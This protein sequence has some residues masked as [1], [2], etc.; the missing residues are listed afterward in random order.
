[1]SAAELTADYIVVGAGTAGSVLARRL[2]DAGARVLLL[3][4]GGPA[5]NPAIDDPLRMHE[6]WHS[7][8]DWDYFT[9]PQP[10]A[11]GRRLHLPRGRVIGGS[12]ALNAT[13]HVRGNPADYD[14]WAALGNTG[15]AWR[16]VRPVFERI[17]SGP[18]RFHTGFE[19]DPVQSAILAA[20][21]ETGIPFNPD[22]NSGR[23]EGVSTLALTLADGRRCTTASTYLT[24]VLDRP[25]LTVLSGAEAH[26]L[27]FSGGRVSGVRFARA[28]ELLEASAEAEVVLAAGALGSP[29]LL[30]RSGIGPAD[31]L[32]AADV[33]VLL[34]LPG[35][36]RNLQDHWLVPVIFS[37]ER[38]IRHRPGLPHAQTHLFWHSGEGLPAP[39]LQPLHFSVPLYEPW[40]SGPPNGFSLM[41]GLVRPAGTGTVAIT[42]PD[43]AHELHIDPG[44]LA[45]ES[46]LTRLVAAVRLCQE[47]GH[48]P[49]L[50]EWGADERY[51]GR[52]DLTDYVR[53][54]V[55]TYHHQAGTCRMGV[56]EDAVVGPDLL[57]RGIDGLR[58]ADASIMPAV[59]TGNTNTPAILIAEQAAALLGCPGSEASRIQEVR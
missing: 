25:N 34:D 17:E 31:T 8:E 23:Q 22:Y 46:D 51:P 10:S 26:R 53:R 59:T 30:Q 54:A 40:M 15:W 58:V 4:A 44:V 36:G 48:A 33:P 19:P 35:V 11:A 12:H 38:E 18:L 52:A 24:P 39:D 27:L 28:G 7:T 21:Q 42:G 29:A 43:P 6:L 20:A 2:V 47:I 3:E 1:M 50:W 32:R 56:H 13:I 49:A 16:D 9:V 57:V 14:H 45:A 5:T 55:L 37:A 41:A